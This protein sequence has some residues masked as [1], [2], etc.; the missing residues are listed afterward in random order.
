MYVELSKL[1][2]RKAG[3]STINIRIKKKDKYSYIDDEDVYNTL[4]GS[5]KILRFIIRIVY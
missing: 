5:I 4:H 1:Q 3:I 2:K